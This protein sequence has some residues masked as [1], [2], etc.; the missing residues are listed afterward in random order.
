VEQPTNEPSEVDEPRTAPDELT[1]VSA[2]PPQFNEFER[3]LLA[4]VGVIMPDR[5]AT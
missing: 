1:V 4:V 3:L 2:V 5:F